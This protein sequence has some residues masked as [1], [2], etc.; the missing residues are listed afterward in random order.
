MD[1]DTKENWYAVFVT[2]GDEDN[3]KERINYKFKE[4]LRA[5]VPKRKLRERKKGIWEDK[6]R[7]LL[8]GYVLLNGIIVNNEFEIIKGIPGVIRLLMSDDKPAH[9]EKYE[10]ELI[11]RLTCDGDI[12]ERSKVYIVGNKVL[13]KEGP[14]LGMDGYIKSVD[15][16]KGRVKV[17]MQLMGQP[18]EVEL[19]VELVESA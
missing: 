14:L 15:K 4:H 10:I 9:I 17:M 12:I 18:R 5:I 7:T 13:V 8:P 6:L 1:Y 2:T 16:R 3:V 11:E 19:S